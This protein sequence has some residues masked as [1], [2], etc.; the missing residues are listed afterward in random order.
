[1]K[2]AQIHWL[3]WVD[4]LRKMCTVSNESICNI[5]TRQQQRPIS[6]L[7]KIMQTSKNFILQHCKMQQI[8][9]N[10]DISTTIVR[11]C[12]SSCKHTKIFIFNSKSDF[13]FKNKWDLFFANFKKK[14]KKFF[15]LFVYFF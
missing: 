6:G 11:M 10:S 5:I 3:S 14:N 12:P 1:M 13:K 4:K 15:F 7:K 9:F 2:I 8:C